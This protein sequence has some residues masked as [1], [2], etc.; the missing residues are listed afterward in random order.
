MPFVGVIEPIISSNPGLLPYQIQAIISFAM[1]A[2]RIIFTEIVP[3]AML[4]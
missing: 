2:I 3:N 1:E 4:A